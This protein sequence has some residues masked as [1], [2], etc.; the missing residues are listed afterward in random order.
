VDVWWHDGWWEG[1]VVHKES[2]DRLQ[3]YFP[4][5]KQYLTFNHGQLRHSQEWLR[6]GWEQIKERPDL[7]T[8]LVSQLDKKQVL[9]KS[10]NG[11]VE[12]VA[13]CESELVRKDE[14]GRSDS[15]QVSEFGKDVKVKEHEVVTD[16][17]KDNLLTQLKWKSSRKRRRGSG[18]SVQK[19]H[20]I[21]ADKDGT[22]DVMVSRTCERFLIP[23]SLKVDHENCKFVGDSLFSSSVVPPLTSLVM[24]R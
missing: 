19:M 17:S 6:N 2:D 21:V 1:I 15:C 12:Q 10:C 22:P 9:G 18:S 16:L 11:S 3:V 5:E 24:S 8:S 20:Y 4:G 13:I 7:A 14:S 23:T